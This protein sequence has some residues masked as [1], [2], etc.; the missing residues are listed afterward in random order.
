MTRSTIAS[1]MDRSPVCV[2]VEGERG[3]RLPIPE[4]KRRVRIR[5]VRACVPRPEFSIQCTDRKAMMI[6]RGYGR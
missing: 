1:A 2:E 6:D 4:V 3:E 5:L